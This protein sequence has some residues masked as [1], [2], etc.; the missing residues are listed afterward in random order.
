MVK[1]MIMGAGK[2][3]VVAPLLALMLADGDSLVLSVIPK[4]LLEMSRKIFR[5]TFATVMAKRIYTLKFER[6]TNVNG[7]LA[8][9]LQNAAKNRGIVVATPTSVKSVALVYVETLG[10]V[11]DCKAGTFRGKPAEL[12]LK[13]NELA[14]VLTLFKKGVMLLDEVDLILHPLKS[15]LN[16]PCG[17]KF[18][19][20]VS[21]QGE[22]W[23]LPMHLCDAIF[24]AMTKR[25][26]TFEGRGAAL[27][28]LTRLSEAIET[29]YQ[30]KALQ[31]LP[32]ITMLNHDYYDEEVKP[33]MAEWAYLWLQKMHLHGVD[34]DDAVRYILE[35][36]AAQS[37]ATTKLDLIE[38]E[39]ARIRVE[40]GEEAEN[41]GM[42][43]GLE[44][45]RSQAERDAEKE[46]QD[47]LCRVRS[48][49]VKGE[50]ELRQKLE[51]LV[52]AARVSS[53]HRGHLHEV[54][55]IETNFETKLK[56]S[57][58][59]LTRI[60]TE[61]S[62]IE[63][64]IK[65]L[66]TPRDSSLD[67]SVVVWY[68]HAFGTSLGAGQEGTGT[69]EVHGVCNA[70]EE[71]GLTVRRVDNLEET[72]ERAR[73]LML[74]GQL[75]AII[76]GG[77][78]RAQMKDDDDD[79][80]GDGAGDDGGTNVQAIDFVTALQQILDEKNPFAAQH[81]PLPATG[82]FVFAADTS[83]TADT[84][85]ALWKCKVSVLDDKPQ[86]LANL[87]K[88]ATAPEEEEEIEEDN[89]AERI[90]ELQLR[91]ETLEKEK[92]ASQDAE[93]EER[94]GLQGGAATAHSALKASIEKRVA[95]LEAAAAPYD[96]YATPGDKNTP[97]NAIGPCCGRD[98][99]IAMAWLATQEVPAE[100]A[101]PEL[102]PKI[103]RRV[104]EI[105]AEISHL[106]K[107][108]LAAKVMALVPS[109][110]HKKLLNLTHDWL[111]TFLPHCLAKVNR[112]TI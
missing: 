29:G 61:V 41:P 100:G 82:L 28:I 85:L 112:V 92:A 39:A 105:Y 32:H 4:A 11:A 59:S 57:A 16:F 93:E 98:A 19:L 89:H 70:M 10:L 78:E 49:N 34:R 94:K 87:A 30:K 8:A 5:E 95:R 43:D 20:D 79:V 36:A 84:R 106:K 72:I 103:K 91:L 40:L 69:L 75:R 37:E 52:E 81:G 12:E 47:E 60:Q 99:A 50:Q 67:N 80:F 2:T 38:M 56:Q 44:R 76:L 25:V 55:D 62:S 102:Q 48:T 83:L 33:I 108:E 13:A 24:F 73:H 42:T 17:D 6:S 14:Q 101:S 31:R 15:E 58:G 21:E 104:A 97:R 53:E 110:A 88:L 65:E 22:R 1:Q 18:D 86:T 45:T 9:R 7:T 68:S 51:H 26:T 46:K 111:R 77:G 64:E 107:V 90:A 71:D 35:G 23:S 3:T 109:P 54:F 27:G 66:E 74:Q 63:K 96:A